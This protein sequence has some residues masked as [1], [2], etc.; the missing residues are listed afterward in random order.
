MNI[1]EGCIP[2][3]SKGDFDLIYTMIE[4]ERQQMQGT[5]PEIFRT[6]NSKLVVVILNFRDCPPTKTFLSPKDFNFC[7]H[8]DTKWLVEQWNQ[9][10]WDIDTL[11]HPSLLF[12]ACM[13][14]GL[15]LLPIFRFVTASPSDE[16]GQ[17][18]RFKGVGC[19]CWGQHFR[20]HQPSLPPPISPGC[21]NKIFAIVDHWIDLADRDSCEI[22][23]F[24]SLKS[25]FLP[26]CGYRRV[27]YLITAAFYST[28]SGA[29]LSQSEWGTSC[30]VLLVTFIGCCRGRQYPV[31]VLILLEVLLFVEVLRTVTVC[32]QTLN[33]VGVLLC[34]SWYV[35]RDCIPD[36]LEINVQ[37][38][39]NTYIDR[40]N[41][42]YKKYS[43]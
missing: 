7:E 38:L 40:W 13:E 17:L 16:P 22:D 2:D 31:R 3:I 35:N 28:C 4:R 5:L 21:F 8:H 34:D 11:P 1:T 20:V 10:R 15:S 41:F 33:N 12:I 24:A 29:V 43:N 30:L 39:L 6:V 32:S 23:Y 37:S 36:Q 18:E 9:I 26:C 25:L 27:Y 42:K 14:R 19:S